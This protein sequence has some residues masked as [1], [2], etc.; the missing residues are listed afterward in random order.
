MIF[1]KDYFKIENVQKLEVGESVEHSGGQLVDFVSVEHP[2]SKSGVWSVIRGGYGVGV[3]SQGGETL[4][5]L[6]GVRGD[7]RNPIVAEIAAT[8]QLNKSGEGAGW[9]GG[10]LTSG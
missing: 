7:A 6:E 10:K 4:E 8:Q 1:K 3:N 2:A 5:A 9:K